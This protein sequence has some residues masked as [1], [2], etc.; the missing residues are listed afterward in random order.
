M[1]EQTTGYPRTGR[2]YSVRGGPHFYLRLGRA[3]QNIALSRTPSWDQPCYGRFG[4]WF[5]HRG[6]TLRYRGWLLHFTVRS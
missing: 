1:N 2:L 5:H 6:L 3:Y 4:A